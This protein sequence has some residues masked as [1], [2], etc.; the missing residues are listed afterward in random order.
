[1]NLPEGWAED[2][3]KFELPDGSVCGAHVGYGDPRFHL[4]RCDEHPEFGDEDDSED[5]GDQ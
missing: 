4:E 1:M 5:R 3:C 2:T